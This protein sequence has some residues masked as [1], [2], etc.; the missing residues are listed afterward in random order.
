MAIVTYMGRKGN[1]EEWNDG[2]EKP[3]YFK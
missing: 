2:E 3:A 1:D